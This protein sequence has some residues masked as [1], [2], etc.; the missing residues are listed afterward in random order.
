MRSTIGVSEG[1]T[2]L[3]PGGG[4][5]VVVTWFPL[6][7]GLEVPP[8]GPVAVIGGMVGVRAVVRVA[9]GRFGTVVAGFNAA[10]KGPENRK[11][12]RL[13]NKQPPNTTKTGQTGRGFGTGRGI[14]A[15]IWIGGG[16]GGGAFNTALNLPA[17][18][19]RWLGLSDMAWA[20]VRLS[21]GG[22]W[23][24]IWLAG[25]SVSVATRCTL[26]CG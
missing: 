22:M 17:V 14:G 8:E 1:V 2:S 13:R 10:I 15:A 6:E 26:S 25:T 9:A 16:G 24:S 21:S 4:L 12:A 18:E 20:I 7:P 3:W 19:N 23:G 5:D 11:T